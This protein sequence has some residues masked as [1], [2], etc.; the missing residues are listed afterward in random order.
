MK[1]KTGRDLSLWLQYKL[2]KKGLSGA[3]IA[4]RAGVTRSFVC[5]VLQGKQRGQRVRQIIAEA[6]G[7]NI[8]KIWQEDK[9]H[10]TDLPKENKL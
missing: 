6:L 3:E 2:R 8:Q 1:A 10:G 5:R 9:R 4:R 7:M